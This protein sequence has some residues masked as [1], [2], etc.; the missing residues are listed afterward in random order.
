MLYHNIYIAPWINTTFFGEVGFK[1]VKNSE[2]SANLNQET[3]QDI[4][5]VENIIEKAIHV[6]KL[7]NFLSTPGQWIFMLIYVCLIILLTVEQYVVIEQAR[8][9]CQLCL[10]PYQWQGDVCEWLL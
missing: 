1:K 6:P 9:I 3:E 8:I 4:R 7:F 5:D 2:S 10:V